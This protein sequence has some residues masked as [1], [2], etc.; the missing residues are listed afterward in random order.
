[1]LLGILIAAILLAGA[2]I[3]HV[4]LKSLNKGRKSFVNLNSDAVKIAFIFVVLVS[5]A[6][7]FALTLDIASFAIVLICV[8]AIWW[9]RR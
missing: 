5:F 4:G 1:M 6:V 8:A 7:D 9:L 3:Y 2:T